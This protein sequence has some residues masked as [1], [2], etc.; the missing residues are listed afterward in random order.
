[1]NLNLNAQLEK[2]GLVR[3]K[4]RVIIKHLIGIFDLGNIYYRSDRIKK[5]EI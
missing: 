3:I 1:M 2:K 4:E 5:P